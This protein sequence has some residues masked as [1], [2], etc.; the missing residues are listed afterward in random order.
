MD[1][2]RQ[3]VGQRNTS[4]KASRKEL[5]K[6]IKKL[7]RTEERYFQ[8]GYDKVVLKMHAQGWDHKAILDED[9]DDP[10]GW[11]AANEPL[12]VFS[13]PEDGDLSE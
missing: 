12:V 2:L 9:K 4:L 13:D 3:R 8:M 1:A 5:H 6:T 10:V 11:E 7:E